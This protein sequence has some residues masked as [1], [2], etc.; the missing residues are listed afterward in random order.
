[1]NNFNQL[2]ATM[3]IVNIPYAHKNHSTKIHTNIAIAIK[4]VIF[5]CCVLYN[6]V[7]ELARIYN[8][9]K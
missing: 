2:N 7:G 1:M 9:Q 6:I 8:Q 4:H 5:I 3:V